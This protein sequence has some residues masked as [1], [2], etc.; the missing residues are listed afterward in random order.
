VTSDGDRF[1]GRTT[2]KSVTISD[3]LVR[4]FADVIDDHNPLHLDEAAASES[5]FGT[6]IAHGMLVGSMFSGLIAGELPGPGSIYLSQSL[7]FRKPT[8]LGSLVHV[9]VACTGV[10]RGRATLAT[11]V[12]GEDGEMLVDGDAVV[13]LPD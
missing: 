7:R 11:T 10:E 13:L 6:R 8:I 2:T 12:T 3:S 4:Q 9:T 1:L 5:R